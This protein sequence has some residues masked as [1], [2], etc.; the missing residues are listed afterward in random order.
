MLLDSGVLNTRLLLQ[1]GVKEFQIEDRCLVGGD[2]V[3]NLSE[4][5]WCASTLLNF[6]FL[7]GSHT[8]LLFLLF[9]KLY[10]VDVWYFR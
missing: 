1:V 3:A 2:D 4:L 10:V 8:I 5:F 7:I 9:W 6:F